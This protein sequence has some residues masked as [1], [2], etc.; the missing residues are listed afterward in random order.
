MFAIK[1]CTCATKVFISAR[2]GGNLFEMGLAYATFV[3]KDE[4]KG[5]LCATRLPNYSKKSLT[6]SQ[7]MGKPSFGF[8]CLFFVTFLS[9]KMEV[10]RMSS[11]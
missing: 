6:Y 2:F 10:V 8:E 4:T 1:R 5:S 3:C 9:S 7:I 11:F